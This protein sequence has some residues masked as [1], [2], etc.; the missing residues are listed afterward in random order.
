MNL[1]FDHYLE[2]QALKETI[3][4]YVMELMFVIMRI[5]VTDEPR[6]W[7]PL[8]FNC[9]LSRKSKFMCIFIWET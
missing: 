1:H 4:R 2:L 5:T 8:S 3:E 6:V 7:S 9:L